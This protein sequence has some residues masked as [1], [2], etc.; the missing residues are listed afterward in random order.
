VTVTATTDNFRATTQSTFETCPTFITQ[1]LISDFCLKFPPA[2]IR[3]LTSIYFPT[4]SVSH[5][6]H[7]WSLHSLPQKPQINVC[8][9]QQ[10]LFTTLLL[11]PTVI[12]DTVHQVMRV[13]LLIPIYKSRPSCRSSSS[14]CNMATSVWH[15]TLNSRTCLDIPPQ[16]LGSRWRLRQNTGGHMEAAMRFGASTDLVVRIS[17]ISN[18]PAPQS[19]FLQSN[20]TYVITSASTRYQS[21][22][23]RSPPEYFIP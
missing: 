9:C 23:R 7:T 5:P 18:W 10:A 21:I 6:R 8:E 13:L 17:H 20:V 12:P 16:T 2:F 15:K 1:K 4:P 14:V 3:R 22:C 19:Y 11:F